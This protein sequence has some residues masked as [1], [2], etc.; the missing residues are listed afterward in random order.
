MLHCTLLMAPM[1][2]PELCRARPTA[3]RFILGLRAVT[4]SHRLTTS[5]SELCCSLSV[6][7]ASSRAILAVRM[8]KL[9]S[10][11]LQAQPL[12]L[13]AKSAKLRGVCQCNERSS[14]LVLLSAMSA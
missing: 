8:A 7:S 6:I 13:S 4:P 9:F 3:V 12:L 14:S 10:R 11:S 5:I 1:A 2:W